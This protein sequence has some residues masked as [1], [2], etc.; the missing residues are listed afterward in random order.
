MLCTKVLVFE[1]HGRKSIKIVLIWSSVGP[2][3]QGSGNIYAIL[4]KG[5][6]RNYSVKLF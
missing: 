1:V 6:M 4:V 5:I 2:F 3:V